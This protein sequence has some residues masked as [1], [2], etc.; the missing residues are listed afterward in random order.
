MIPTVENA[1]KHFGVERFHPA[2]KNGR[3]RRDVFHRDHLCP[4]VFDDLLRASSGIDG[5]TQALEFSHDGFEALFVKDGNER[6]FDLTG[7]R[8]G[9]G[10]G[11]VWKGAKLQ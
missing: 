1:S 4:H 7:F 5:H 10:R 8:H 3:V 6:R 9:N 2:S 11:W